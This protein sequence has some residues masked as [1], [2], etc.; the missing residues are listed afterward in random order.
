MAGVTEAQGL[1]SG[2][3]NPKIVFQTDF[4]WISSIC[5]L[6]AHFSSEIVNTFCA[7]KFLGTYAG[8]L[9]RI[10]YHDAAAEIRRVLKEDSSYF[11]NLLKL[12]TLENGNW[13]KFIALDMESLIVYEESIMKILEAVA[14]KETAWFEINHLLLNQMRNCW[15]SPEFGNRYSINPGHVQENDRKLVRVQ[16]FPASK[17]NTPHLLGKIFIRYL[18]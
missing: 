13:E 7:K 9:C 12:Y 11:E 16:T 17:L 18:K 3:R 6:T 1:L 4:G 2:Y 8:F 10:L 15:S 14:V 5:E